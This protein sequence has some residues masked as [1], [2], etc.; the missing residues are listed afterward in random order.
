M[1]LKNLYEKE[2]ETSDKL[3]KR[4]EELNQQATKQVN[5]S[6]IINICN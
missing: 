4:I 1:N 2:R 5:I 6:N 3:R